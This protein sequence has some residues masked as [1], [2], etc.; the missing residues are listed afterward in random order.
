MFL[1][2]GCND[3]GEDQGFYK[4]KQ[5]EAGI[6]V[7]KQQKHLG[8]SEDQSQRDRNGTRNVV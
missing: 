6:W 7:P 1:R 2:G 3:I 5:E 8:Y 4:E